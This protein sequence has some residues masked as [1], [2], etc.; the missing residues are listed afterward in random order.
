MRRSLNPYDIAA[1]PGLSLD[2]VDEPAPTHARV[3]RASPRE[4]LTASLVARINIPRAHEGPGF[5]ALKASD[6]SARRAP[7]LSSIGHREATSPS[8]LFHVKRRRIREIISQDDCSAVWRYRPC[9][10][11]APQGPG[12]SFRSTLPELGTISTKEDACRS[13]PNLSF[14]GNGDNVT[15]DALNFR[16]GKPVAHVSRE[17]C[18]IACIHRARLQRRNE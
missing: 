1:I 10:N 5:G 4:M 14:V 3:P 9:A 11:S 16:T 13:S 8:R 17:T 6:V 12:R 2:P 15:R 7:T 18:R